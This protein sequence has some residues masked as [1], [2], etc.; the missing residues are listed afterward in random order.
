M[1]IAAT[2]CS[3]EKNELP[4]TTFDFY[5]NPVMRSDLP[6]PAVI[7]VDSIWYVYASQ[8]ASGI[9]PT[10]MSKDLVNWTELDP[11][12]TTETKPSFVSGATVESPEITTIGGQYV[13]YYSLNT[14]AASGIGV[15][16]ASAPTGPW[17]D[18]GAIATSATLGLKGVLNPSYIN[19][20]GENY[21]AFGS[22]SGLYLIKLSGDG[23]SMDTS[24]SPVLIANEVFDAPVIIK[25]DGLYY[26]IA[27]VGL[28]SGGASCACHLAAGRSENIAGPY[29]TKSVASMTDGGYEDLVA[30]SVKFQGPGHSSNIFLDA[31]GDSWMLYNSYDLSDVSLGRTLMLDKVKWTDGWPVVRGAISSF[32]TDV[33][34][35]K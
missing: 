10:L 20:G 15:A 24:Y 5:R 9:I 14:S 16:T 35:V 3:K 17:T 11:V 27:S 1:L 28:D 30:S 32:C 4:L 2:S 19:D 6:D 33:P 7:K 26:L 8:N 29:L 25:Q 22:F 13:L 18:H 31:E 21:L 23:L 12:F 34:V